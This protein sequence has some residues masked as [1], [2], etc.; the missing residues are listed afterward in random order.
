MKVVSAN[1]QTVLHKQKKTKKKQNKNKKIEKKGVAHAELSNMMQCQSGV[2]N[3]SSLFASVNKLSLHK[4]S[5][6]VLL[7]L[8]PSGRFLLFP[9]VL[10]LLC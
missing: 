3:M 2:K 4:S 5:T 8:L 7:L 1:P 10:Q 6:A 9:F